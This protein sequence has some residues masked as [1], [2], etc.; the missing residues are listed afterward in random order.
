MGSLPRAS[1][2][3]AAAERQALAT[4]RPRALLAGAALVLA[5]AYVLPYVNFTLGK[6][7]WAFR[8]LG[9]GPMFGLVLL[10]WPVNALLRRMRPALAF[11]GPELL[12]MYAMM[13]V[14]AALSGEG[15]F[16]Y[17]LV[18][19]V[20][21]E[22]YATR[23]NRWGELFMRDV[24]TWMQ[25]TRPD[26]VR[27][28]YEGWP[29]GTP[30]PW[31]HWVAPIA[32]WSVFAFALFTA[33]FCLSCLLRKDWIEGQRLS[34]PFAAVPIELVGEEGAQGGHSL[35]RSRIFWV[36]ASL[37][38][39]QS[40]FQ[41]AHALAPAVPYSPMYWQI[42]RA[43]GDTGPWSAI[44]NTYAYIGFETIG[45]L[46]LLPAEVS[47]SLW[48]FFVLNRAQLFA[49]S[50]L[51]FGQEAIGAR[52]FSPSSFIAYQ[53]AG[54]CLMLALILLWQSRKMIAAGFLRLAGRPAPHDT[55][56]PLSP[57][58][59]ALG[60]VL[61]GLV[62]CYWASRAGMDLWA[63]VAFIAICL[64]YSL[65][66]TR[67]VVAGGIYVPSTSLMPRD[68]LFGLTG[69]A[70][71]SVPS[72]ALVTYLQ[73]TFMAQPKVGF[74]HFAFNS[75]KVMHSARAR[76]GLALLALLAAVVLMMLVV[77][78]TDLSAIYHRG[79]LSLDSWQFRD[80]GGWVFGELADSVHNPEGPTPFLAFGLLCGGAVMLALTWLHTN[81]LWWGLSPLGFVMGGTW[82][83]N[84]RIWTNAF[85]AWVLVVALRRFGGLRLYRTWRPS[86]VGMMVG[87]LII[88][89]VRSFVD[90]MLGLH[91]QLSPWA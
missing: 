24:P 32:A 57:G 1:G 36:G 5:L 81:F 73:H 33:L 66:M 14:C 26:A 49:F 28:F 61:S 64:G 63:F 69:A 18:N 88:M 12:L 47:L 8:P 43:F 72:M 15:L 3:P 62:L 76:G 44:S 4:I 58:A 6:F 70:P 48:F 53:E 27:G 23:E 35:F 30:L 38:I 17:V 52:V 59:A 67:M 37:P 56:D 46:A 9:V 42:G 78:W 39:I 68:I 41:M 74:M 19:T 31:H 90:P 91:M 80:S 71:Y 87:H 82:A 89:G 25:V 84:T 21:P 34:F 13:A 65:A 29:A 11:T 60:L 85:L 22:Y 45:I 83:M 54:A 75:L 7:D 10:I 86:F 40:L 77:P 51:G 16:V 2:A 79:A 20:H 55:L 50:A